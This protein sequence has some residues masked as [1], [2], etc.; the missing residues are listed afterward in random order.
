MF[1]RGT[2]PYYLRSLA[3]WQQITIRITVCTEAYSITLVTSDP[4]HY[5]SILYKM[6][7]RIRYRRYRHATR[8]AYTVSHK[9]IRNL[10]WSVRSIKGWYTS[11]CHPQPFAPT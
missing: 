4:T 6:A 9:Y 10:T 2:S 11:S 7:R 1:C 5:Y 3:C 8:P